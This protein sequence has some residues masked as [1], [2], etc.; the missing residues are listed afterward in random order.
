M[1]LRNNKIS[2][3]LVKDFTK[4]RFEQLIYIKQNKNNIIYIKLYYTIKTGVGS[5]QNMAV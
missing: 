3:Y 2:S 5:S 4:A 1:C